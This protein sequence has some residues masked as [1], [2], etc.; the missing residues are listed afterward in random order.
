MFLKKIIDLLQVTMETPKAFG[1][2]HWLTIFLMIIPII[3]LY[4]QKYSEKQLKKVLFIYGITALILEALKNI[5]WAFNYNEITNT[6]TWDYEWYAFPFQLCSTPIYISLICS[7]LKRTKLR[8][9]LLS[10]LAFVTIIGSIS[11][12][13]MPDSCFTSEILININTTWIHYG[14]FVVSVYL[15]M[16]GVVK[17]N[18]LNLKRALI[19]F[20]TCASI[21]LLLN[22][23]IY[24]IGILN[25]ETFNMFYIS[26]YF[27]SILPVFDIIQQNVPYII[28]LFS[29]LLAITIGATI[30]YFIAK[31]IKNKFSL[32]QSIH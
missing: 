11:A 5:S 14:A 20:I 4:K 22:I 23:I 31:L 6:I 19:V 7:F 32:K 16:K 8:T 15:L 28:F 2:F 29:Y 25:G 10:Y 12:L 9:S 21:A 13:I 17:P 1:W 30:I 24:N 27:I 3:F 26:P 18:K